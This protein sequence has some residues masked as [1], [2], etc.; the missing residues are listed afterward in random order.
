MKL[1]IMLKKYDGSLNKYE[2]PGETGNPIE[3]EANAGAG[4]LLRNFGKMY[5][6]I[7][8]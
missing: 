1:S 7:F 5:P 4:I 8:E 6:Q 3:N 2:N